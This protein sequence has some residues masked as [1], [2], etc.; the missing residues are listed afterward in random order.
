[1]LIRV[2]IINYNFNIQQNMTVIRKNKTQK[3]KYIRQCKLKLVNIRHCK[4]S[5][6]KFP[7]ISVVST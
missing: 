7:N 3:S 6:S 1:M 4:Q 5:V 2:N